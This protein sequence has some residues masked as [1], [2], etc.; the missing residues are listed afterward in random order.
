MK[1]ARW[2]MMSHPGYFADV[3]MTMVT[4]TGEHGQMK[5]GLLAGVIDEDPHIWVTK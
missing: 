1:L 2:F 3:I 4:L 5:S